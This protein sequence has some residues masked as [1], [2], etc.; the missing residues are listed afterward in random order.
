MTVVG[1]VA[2]VRPTRPV[3]SRSVGGSYR[4]TVLLV[5]TFAQAATAAFYLGLPAIGPGLR[6]ELGL[7]LAGLGLLLG[8]PTAGLVLTLIA[9]GRLSDHL[10][11]RAVMTAGLVAT[12]VTLAL[13]PVATSAVPLG[14]LLLLAGA[15]AACV[16][17]ASG[18]AVLTWFG[19][20]QRGLA[21]AIRHTA[22]PGGAA[23]AAAGLP[24]IVSSYGTGVAYVTLAVASLAAGAAVWAWIREP[25]PEPEAASAPEPAAASAPEP[26]AVPGGAAGSMRVLGD[27]RLLRLG[28]AS[29]LLVVGQFVMTAFAV[30]LVHAEAHLTAAAAAAVLAA[31]QLAGAIGRLVAGWWSDRVGSRLRPLRTVAF[32][33]AAGFVALALATRGPAALLVVMVV[34]LSAVVICWNGLGFVAAAELAPPDRVGTALGM[35]NTIN[36]A[37]A[38]VTPAVAGAIIGA[39]GWSVGLL[40]FAL[41]PLLCAWLITPLVEDRPRRNGTGPQA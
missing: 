34:L 8:A 29:A 7:S 41:P 36:F 24:W 30:E 14:A 21:M 9:W 13:A 40:L 20:R 39:T 32:A 19:P 10:G 16:N 18:R 31:G 38:S 37:S 1:D 25:D 5:G 28:S 33:A 12:A 11:E 6:A 22:I 2:V 26:A 3:P 35:Q 17:A 23:L 27:P 4:W 15:G